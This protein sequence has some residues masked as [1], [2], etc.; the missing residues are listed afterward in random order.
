MI[1][2]PALADR[3][4]VA[5]FMK[6]TISRGTL[7][8]LVER[9]P[10]LRDRPWARIAVGILSAAVALVMRFA[11]DGIVPPGYPFL[12]LFPAILLATFIFGR[13]T[14][15]VA[16]LLCGIGAWYWFIAPVNGFGVNAGSITAM[17]FYTVI[18]GTAVYIIDM[19]QRATALAI[20]ERERA[21]A[22]AETRGLLFREL[23][24]RVSNNLQV[25]GALLGAQRRRVT[26]P[27][28]RDAIAEA[29]NRLTVIGQISRSLYQADGEQAALDSFLDG[30]AR[31]VLSSSG[32]EDV[33]L[34]LDVEPGLSLKVD[35]AL[36]LAIVFAENLSNALEH[37]LAGRSGT[38]AVRVASTA[39]NRLI[40]SVTDDGAGLRD[41]FDLATCNSLG[42]HIVG[43]L[44]K[45]LGG[46]F[47]LTAIDP[48]G[49]QAILDIPA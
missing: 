6:T 48:Q 5:D 32:R 28:A 16:A 31:A 46:T 2:R 36:P 19:A 22:L 13:L 12:T 47:T 40:M 30:L 3:K 39:G 24:H 20:H 41:G 8:R 25:I 38:I 29:A 37:G 44:A 49:T 10:L 7:G 45:Q 23:Q 27:A 18:V 9:F 1:V 4:D 14:G 17:L 34:T 26:D 15:S 33:A 11:L 43:Q 21:A 42:L 35:A